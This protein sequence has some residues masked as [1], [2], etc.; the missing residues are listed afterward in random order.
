MC[1]QARHLPF[2]NQPRTGTHAHARRSPLPSPRA[3]PRAQAA[4]AIRRLARNNADTQRAIS[5][6]QRQQ[7]TYEIGQGPRGASARRNVRGEAAGQMAAPPMELKLEA[8]QSH[9]RRVAEERPG[10]VPS[11]RR[12]PP[13]SAGAITA[14]E[15]RGAGGVVA[16]SGSGRLT[17]RP[18]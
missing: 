6:A 2:S 13:R 8:L 18:S 4:G 14:T 15:A 5:T 3:A 12:T 7:G 1:P 17:R 11:D 10:A 9:P 16:V